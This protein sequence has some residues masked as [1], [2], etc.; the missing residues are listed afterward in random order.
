MSSLLSGVH[1]TL[2]AAF[3]SLYPD[4]TLHRIA[5]VKSPAADPVRTETDYACKAQID[6]SMT[7]NRPD[8]G[9]L[10]SKRYVLILVDSLSVLPMP[11]DKITITPTE[12]SPETLTIVEI[13]ERDPANVYYRCEVT[14]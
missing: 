13:A 11:Q 12:G 5:E 8:G 14:S 9:T 1:K 2:S 7:G 10:V 6:D 4:A 3:T